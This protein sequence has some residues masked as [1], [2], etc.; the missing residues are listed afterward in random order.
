[1]CDMENVYMFDETDP[2]MVKANQRARE[3][4][5]YFWR[6]LS[7]EKRRI[8]PGLDMALVKIA[9]FADSVPEGNHYSAGGQ[10]RT[11]HGL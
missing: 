11:C 7:W 4:F 9:F 8:V 3:T 1:M 6:E 10:V 5:K 2:E